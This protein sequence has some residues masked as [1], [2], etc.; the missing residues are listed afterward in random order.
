MTSTPNELQQTYPSTHIMRIV[1]PAAVVAAAVYIKI[2]AMS[3]QS[4]M[5]NPDESKNFRRPTC[6]EK[7]PNKSPKTVNTLNQFRKNTINLLC[8]QD[9]HD[10]T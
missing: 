3:A 9:G 10:K 1:S 6:R 4:V 7:L 2:A 8:T 5:P